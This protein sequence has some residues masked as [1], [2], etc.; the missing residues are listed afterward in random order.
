MNISLL[1]RS[2]L[3]IVLIGL[4]IPLLILSQ[5]AGDG[6]LHWFVFWSLALNAF[7]IF[8]APLIVMPLFLTP[9]LA[10][11]NPFR[12][13]INIVTGLVLG[14]DVFTGIALALLSLIQVSQSSWAA[15]WF[16]LVPAL[17]I[18]LALL[19]GLVMVIIMSQNEKGHGWWTVFAVVGL[20]GA[21]ILSRSM[22]WLE[23]AGLAFSVLLCLVLLIKFIQTLRAHGT[24]L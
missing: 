23:I 20:I 9:A 3:P 10:A 22:F 5:L 6:I 17:C 8:L 18:A 16:A 14:I 15:D 12:H 19:V 1:L 24:P 21:L 11:Q 13:K 7:L 2:C 4:G